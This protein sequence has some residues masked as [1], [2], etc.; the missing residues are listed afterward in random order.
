M[1]NR[2]ELL[3][4]LVELTITSNVS[5]VIQFKVGGSTQSFTG[6][7][8][9]IRVE[10]GKTVGWSVSADGYV[11]QSSTVVMSSNKDVGVSL[12]PNTVQ[13]TINTNVKATI[14]I[15]GDVS[16]GVKSKSMSVTANS[17]VSWSVS[18][19]YYVTQSGVYNIGNDDY[20]MKVNL[21][22]IPYARLDVHLTLEIH[23]VDDYDRSPGSADLHISCPDGSVVNKTLIFY[24]A[25]GYTDSLYFSVYATGTYRVYLDKLTSKSPYSLS[26]TLGY[27]GYAE[28]TENDINKN[29]TL[30]AGSK[31]I[32]VYGG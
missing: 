4:N 7:S 22:P 30:Y 2:R 28:V 12:I 21:V 14:T 20:N 18:A 23:G 25:H 3:V 32:D 13:F 29:N 9:S 8:A 17:R 16:T 31:V 19:N 26:G 27:L 10:Q 1:Q 5:S 15:N 24:S 6:T 11:S